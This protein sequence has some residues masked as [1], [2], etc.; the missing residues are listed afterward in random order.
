MDISK[1]ILS[2]VKRLAW[3]ADNDG[4]LPSGLVDNVF[5]DA[6]ESMSIKKE[7]NQLFVEL[8]FEE[9]VDDERITTKM[10]YT[11]SLNKKLLRIEEV[12]NMGNIIE[13]DRDIIINELIEDIMDYIE[14]HYS[15]NEQIDFFNSLPK[16]ISQLIIKRFEVA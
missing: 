1:M 5:L 7:N 4:V 14:V 13:W 6:Y 8:V 16:D 9:Q 12:G 2:K 10:I 15:R 3:I 11:Y